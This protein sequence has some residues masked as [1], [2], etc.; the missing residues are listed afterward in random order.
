MIRSALR[1]SAALPALPVLLAA[2]AA[3]IALRPRPWAYEWFW[4]VYQ[5]NFVTILIG[6]LLAG[7]AAWEGWRCSA[8][9]D[10]LDTGA[11]PRRVAAVSWLATFLWGL[12]VF[13]VGLVA[14]CVIVRLAGTP[15]AP[16][17]AAIATVLPAIALVAAECAVGLLVGWWVRHVLAA[18]AAALGCFLLSLWL[19]VSGPTVLIQVGGASGSMIGASVRVVPAM[20]QVA[21]FAAIVLLAVLLLAR[22]RPWSRAGAAQSA[23]ASLA[24][25]ATAGILVLGS[26]S[27]LVAQGPDR[28]QPAP[29]ALVCV[30]TAPQVCVA[31][32]YV[33]YAA[34]ARAALLPYLSRL[35][36]AGVPVPA[37]FAQNAN[38][39]ELTVGPIEST[40]L[41]GR[42][43]GAGFA[44]INSYLSKQCPIDQD[45]ALQTE[46]N[47]IISWL[48]A[49]SVPISVDDASIPSIVRGPQTPTQLAWV[50]AAMAHLAACGR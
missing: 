43:D 48:Y 1:R 4:A 33:R 29:E 28:L 19:Y 39:G 16:P 44:V 17:L 46:W 3:H 42:T 12:L 2:V 49:G 14:V 45:P 38:P 21:Y 13:A 15:G 31:A 34:G 26:A 30:G 37:K 32:G 6:P 7:I 25:V 11:Q 22:P 18:P 10:L 8:A 23:L 9:A 27:F 24:P 36:E 35:T 50:K 41:L 5:F 47:G 40:L 20:A